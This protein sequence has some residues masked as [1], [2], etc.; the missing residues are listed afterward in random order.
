[1]ED[2]ENLRLAL[3]DNLGD[4]GYRILPATDCRTAREALSREKFQLAILDIMLPD[5]D[6]YALCR[7]IRAGGAETMV[8]MLTAR[9]LED[10]VVRGFDVGA[11]DYLT[12]PFRLREFLAR[13]KALLRR[14]GPA[15]AAITEFAGY[16]LDP[17]AREVWTPKGRAIDLTRKEY[18]LLWY[19]LNN[20]NKLLSRD[21]ILDQVWGQRV[22]VDT[23]TVDNFVS[24]LKKKLGWGP[25]AGFRINTVRGVGYRLEC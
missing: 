8:M 9:T 18:D 15:P 12:K 10:D 4:E 16:R 7:E 22:I 6:G 14:T 1:V 2:D 13:V 19:F 25:D 5:G 21:Q 3:C 20:R 11:D 17:E 24:S 23:R